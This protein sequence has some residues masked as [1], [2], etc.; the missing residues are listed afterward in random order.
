VS[1]SALRARFRRS[2]G[3]LDG[4]ALDRSGIVPKKDGGEISCFGH[5]S[6]QAEGSN[7]RGAPLGDE[8]SIA[9]GVPVELS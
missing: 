6:E 9:R 3:T 2:T 8:L 4:G 5:A 7:A 1:K